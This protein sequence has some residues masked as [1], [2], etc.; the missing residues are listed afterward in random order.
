MISTLLMTKL[1][2]PPMQDKLVERKRL[3]KLLNEGLRCKLCLLSAP[4]G[5]GKTTLLCE[6][7]SK[8][9]TPVAW[10][11][12]DEKDDDLI[13]FLTYLISALQRIDGRI[14][15]DI[16]SALH[17]SHPPSI[18][19]LLT[20]LTSE[21]NNLE[22]DFILILDDFHL[23]T[24][25]SIFDALGFLLEHL[26]Q[27]MHIIIS[28]RVDPPL[29]LARFRVQG[30]LTEI[31]SSNLQFTGKEVVI[32]LNDLMDLALSSEEIDALEVRT[33]GWIASLKLAALSLRDRCDKHDFVEDFSGSNRYIMDYLMDEVMSRQSEEVQTFLCQTSIF[34]RFCAS[35]CDDVLEI[36]NSRQIIKKLEQENLFL[37][38]LDE[39]RCWYRYHYLFSDFLKQRLYERNRKKLPALHRQAS[40]W[41]ETH[42][43]LDE[44]V[45][46]ALSSG[47][48]ERVACLVEKTAASLTIRKELNKLLRWINLLPDGL[49]QNHPLLCVYHAWALLFT[50]QIN[51]C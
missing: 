16:L 29:P 44:A 11:S 49:R 46:H 31:R 40:Q 41:Y 48:L 33:E 8:T 22:D 3:T 25:Q 5:F 19:Q 17:A 10:L 39:V 51:D 37:I 24:D 9:E 1:N 45:E 50:E 2:I 42:G 15:R 34:G 35:F 7:L 30:Q 47:E 12:L 6:W 23:V 43:Q 21:I 20:R 4:A 36:S 27:K 26:P 32:Y 28:G 38:P 14:G 18:E 13:R